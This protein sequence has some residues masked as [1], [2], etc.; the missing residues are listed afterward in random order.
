[1][2]KLIDLSIKHRAPYEDLLRLRGLRATA[3]RIQV[4]DLLNQP[5]YRPTPMQVCEELQKLNPQL[6]HSAIYFAVRELAKT[7]ILRYIVIGGVSHLD[8]YQTPHHN[9]ICRSCNGVQAIPLEQIDEAPIERQIRGM[10]Y[11][12]KPR[13]LDLEVIC[14]KCMGRS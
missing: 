9:L 14:P 1:M 3:N 13:G 5:Q 6:G 11:H 12:L 4:M 7:G 8:G 10:G 2:A